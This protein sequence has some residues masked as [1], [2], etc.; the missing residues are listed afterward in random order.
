MSPPALALSNAITKSWAKRWRANGWKRNARQR[1]LNPDL[2]ERLLSLCSHHD[3]TFIWV[4]GHANNRENERCDILS[5][6]AAARPDLEADP[7]YPGISPE[8]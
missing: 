1:A 7:G 5:K 3:V 4:R 2:W 6:E 8:A